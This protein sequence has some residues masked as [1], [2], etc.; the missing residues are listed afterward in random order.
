MNL[1]ARLSPNRPVITLRDLVK[2]DLNRHE[3]RAIKAAL[4][5]AK[6]TQDATREK[7]RKIK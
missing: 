1:V 2:P 6:K 7:A 5:N 3:Q 4:K